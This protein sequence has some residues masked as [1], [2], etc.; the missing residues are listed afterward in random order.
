MKIL[1]PLLFLLVSSSVGAQP[2]EDTLFYKSGWER[3]V[4]ILSIDENGR[5]TIHCVSQGKKAA[6]ETNV[7]MSKL[8]YYKSN[9]PKFKQAGVSESGEEFNDEIGSLENSEGFSLRPGM[10]SFSPLDLALLGIGMDYTYRFGKTLSSGVHIPMRVST[11]LGAGFYF[12][13]G[14]GYS[15]FAKTKPNSE[16]LVTAIPTFV[17]FGDEGFG[18]LII[19]M[20][21]TRY[22]NDKIGLTGFAGLG[23]TTGGPLIWFD[24]HFGIGF[25]FGDKLESGKK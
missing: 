12:S 11:L 14:V 4:T 24:V 8:K 20:G 21:G 2:F 10:I 25:R 1:L 18:A 17:A 9:N 6:Y 15:Y 5:G 23:P 22:F 7:S 3:A 19:G 16:F 13:A